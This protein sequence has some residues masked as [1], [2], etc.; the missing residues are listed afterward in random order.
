LEIARTEIALVRRLESGQSR[1]IPPTV[2]NI[3]ATLDFE[4]QDI[5]ALVITELDVLVFE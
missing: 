1:V 4:A 5:Q 2:V 3:H